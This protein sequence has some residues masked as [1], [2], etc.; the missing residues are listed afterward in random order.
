MSLTRARML[1][2]TFAKD[3]A[4]DR[5][6]IVGVTS[7]GI[8]CVP[9]CKAPKPKPEN[10]L[11]FAN[12][13]AAAQ[14]G[15]RACKRCYPNFAFEGL[16][17]GELHFETLIGAV[18][19]RPQDFDGVDA[20]AKWAGVSASRL[21]AGMRTYYHATPLDTLT[22]A[23]VACAAHALLTGNATV[24]NVGA[25]AGFASTSVYYENFSRLMGMSPAAYRELSGATEF[26]IALPEPYPHELLIAY[27]GRDDGDPILRRRSDT[28]QLVMPGPLPTLV[29][30]EVRPTIICVRLSQ[31][32]GAPKAHGLLRRMIGLNQDPRPLD[33]ILNADP[34]FACLAVD[35]GLRVFQTPG[36][37]DA[38]AWSIVGQQ[39][40][41]RFAMVLRRR[42]FELL[43]IPRVDGIYVPLQ[44]SDIAN[45]NPELLLPLQYSQRKAEY[46]VGV[47][48][49]FLR[50]GVDPEALP[51]WPATRVERWLAATRGFGPWST[52]YAMMRGCGYANCVPLG[53][54]GLT[55]GLSR[56]YGLGARPNAQETVNLMKPFEPHRSLAT[57]RIWYSRSLRSAEAASA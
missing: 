29:A 3:P 13:D 6:F 51:S 10:V 32:G 41:V 21:H 12:P 4:F 34:R 2:R 17:P 50:E 56:L 57:F 24:S 53:D 39:I 9:S 27:L 5:R 16:D 7:T 20:M 45:L 44:A 23:R 14:H 15:L 55:S 43:N 33:N 28:F 47:A 52:N 48:Q 49:R 42:L 37:F 11:F 1:D 8:Y 40:T 25:D 35:A 54:T 26:R 46:L 38:I 19:A 31:S 18:R 36:I 22:A 30:F